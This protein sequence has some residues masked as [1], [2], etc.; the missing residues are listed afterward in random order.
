[1]F[2]NAGWA[3]SIRLRLVGERDRDVRRSW[4]ELP[5]ESLEGNSSTPSLRGLSS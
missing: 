2:V 3:A 1:M 5:I 4:R